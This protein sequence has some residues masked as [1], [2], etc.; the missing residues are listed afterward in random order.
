M[1]SYLLVVF[2]LFFE[3]VWVDGEGLEGIGIEVKGGDV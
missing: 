2:F 3:G 1:F